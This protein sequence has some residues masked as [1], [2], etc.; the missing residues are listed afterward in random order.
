MLYATTRRFLEVFGLD[1]LK[2]LPSLRE[3]KELADEKG[4]ALPGSE[5]DDGGGEAAGDGDSS[6]ALEPTAGE[7]ADP[8]ATTSDEGPAV[9]LE[10]PVAT[11]PGQET[12]RDHVAADEAETLEGEGEIEVETES[13]ALGADPE[14]AGDGAPDDAEDAWE[15]PEIVEPGS[16]RNP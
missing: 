6:P 14:V 10:E 1:S 16:D 12:E 4:V 9:Q 3:L 15:P 11:G 13:A 2:S 8:E 5:A 7:A